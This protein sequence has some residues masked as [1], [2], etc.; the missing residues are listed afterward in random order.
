[1]RSGCRKSQEAEDSPSD[2]LMESPVPA[3]NLFM[4]ILRSLEFYALLSSLW[5]KPNE[6]PIS[7][8]DNEITL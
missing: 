4:V 5:A 1:M 7:Y 6:I 2:W 3:L 8:R